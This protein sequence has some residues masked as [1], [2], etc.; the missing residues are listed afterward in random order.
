MIRYMLRD[1]MLLRRKRPT[2][3]VGGQD[4]PVLGRVGMC[5]IVLDVTDLTCEV[6]DA[7]RLPVNPL[8]CD[9]GLSRRYV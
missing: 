6:G 2:G 8:F 9:S 1:L 3:L 5:N 7:V 4:A